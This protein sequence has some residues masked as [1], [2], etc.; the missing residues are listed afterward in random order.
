MQNV[1]RL[2]GCL[3]YCSNRIE[4]MT[5]GAVHDLWRQLAVTYDPQIEWSYVYAQA[6]EE[7]VWW[8]AEASRE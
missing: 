8:L 2:N 3:D 1:T 4:L 7:P 5:R 6:Q